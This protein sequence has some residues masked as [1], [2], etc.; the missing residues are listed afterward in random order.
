MSCLF[1]AISYAAYSEKKEDCDASFLNREN[2]EKFVHDNGVQSISQIVT[3]MPACYRAN[4]VKI[5]KSASLQ[6]ATPKAPR[7]VV[8]LKDDNAQTRCSFNSGKKEDYKEFY[9]KYPGIDCRE[10]TLECERFTGDDEAR[11][12]FYEVKAPLDDTGKVFS[13]HGNPKALAQ[14]S[15]YNPPV[16][17]TACH[18]GIPRPALK[19]DPRPNMERYPFWVGLYGG[20]HDDLFKGDGK[21]ADPNEVK[22]YTE[23]YFP[24]KATNPRYG[25]LIEITDGKLKNKDPKH[26]AS[27]KPV[28]DLHNTLEYQNYHRIARKFYDQDTLNRIRPFRYA[29]LGAI[30]CNDDIDVYRTGNYLERVYDGNE[31]DTKAHFP[32]DSFIP[33]SVRAKF[34]LSYNQ[35][36]SRALVQ[37]QGNIQRQLDLQRPLGGIS[38]ERVREEA[39]EDLANDPTKPY[40]TYR[41]VSAPEFSDIT[42]LAYFAENLDIPSD[43]WAMTFRHTLGF[44]AGRHNT[45]QILDFLLPKLLDA[46]EDHD[47]RDLS[48]EWGKLHV[49]ACKRLRE[50]SLQTLTEAEKHDQIALK[51]KRVLENHFIAIAPTGVGNCKVFPKPPA[52]VSQCINCHVKGDEEY[53]P[54]DDPEK[55]IAR[56]RLPTSS[57]NKQLLADEVESQIRTERMPYSVP[58]TRKEKEELLTYFATLRA[59]DCPLEKSGRHAAPMTHGIQPN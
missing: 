15:S 13:S 45:H 50:K 48:K 56:L 34:S 35:L 59:M 36:A 7:V 44:G 18:R 14:V 5:F 11:F 21:L 17:M 53:F 31:K 24:Y 46:N 49:D 12:E 25:A 8:Y 52:M 32:V 3:N 9:D 26:G 16:C 47:L 41:I 39:S 42:R 55:L 28:T 10:N 4:S 6:C 33:D 30:S 51:D 27:G 20:I 38:D 22:N 37:H 23:Q 54:F 29:I 40:T 57:R 43:D 19:P 58:M 2:L 1:F